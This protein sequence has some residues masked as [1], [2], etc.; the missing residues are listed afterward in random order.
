MWACCWAVYIQKESEHELFVLPRICV[1]SSRLIK[2]WVG[3][4]DIKKAFFIYK[5]RWGNKGA[6]E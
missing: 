6:I 2:A 1:F 4:Y 5:P 3:S